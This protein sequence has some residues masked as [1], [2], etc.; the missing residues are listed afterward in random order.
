MEYLQIP[1]SVTGLFK[2]KEFKKCAGIGESIGYHIQLIL[3]TSWGESRVDPN[4]GCSI[5]EHDFENDFTNGE[6]QGKLEVSIRKSIQQHE[7]RLSNVIVSTQIVES[8]YKQQYNNSMISRIKKR[9]DVKV[10]GKIAA[11]G[12]DYRSSHQLYI[13]PI[14]MD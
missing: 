10:Q 2:Q 4:F 11:I 12:E 3:Y 9:I 14:S 5:W 6:W 1:L 8:E 13:S 7:P